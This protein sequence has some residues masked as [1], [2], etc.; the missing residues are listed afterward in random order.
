MATIFEI[1]SDDF[2]RFLSLSRKG[3]ALPSFSPPPVSTAKPLK[4]IPISELEKSFPIVGN[5]WEWVARLPKRR[6]G[7]PSRPDGQCLPTDEVPPPCRSFQ[8]D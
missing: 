1:R 4:G 2:A 6:P 7:S 8:I 3:E 5:L